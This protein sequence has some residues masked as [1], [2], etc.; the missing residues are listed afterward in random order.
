[1][2]LA[3]SAVHVGPTPYCITVELKSF[4]SAAIITSTINDI[5]VYLAIS[6]KM[7]LVNQVERDDSGCERLNKQKAYSSAFCGGVQKH[8]L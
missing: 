8:Y 2:P 6:F 3:G 7:L 1:M 5:L 4:A